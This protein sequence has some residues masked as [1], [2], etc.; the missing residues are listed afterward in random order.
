MNWI[1]FLLLTPLAACGTQTPIE[2]L[3]PPDTN[4]LT[5]ITVD[6]NTTAISQ[7]ELP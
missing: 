3:E 7:G 1:A 5:R 4:R 2:H 6:H